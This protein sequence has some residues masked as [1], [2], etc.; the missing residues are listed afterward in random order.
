[1][2]K[3]SGAEAKPVLRHVLVATLHAPRSTGATG[4]ELVE[5]V[6]GG[7]QGQVIAQLHLSPLSVSAN[8]RAFPPRREVAVGTTGCTETDRWD[9]MLQT[10]ARDLG[11]ARV[12]R[13]R[14]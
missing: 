14:R 11:T 13:E 8:G 5:I 3:S 10:I 9:P 4:H 6:G 1:V 2:G 12:R 7:A